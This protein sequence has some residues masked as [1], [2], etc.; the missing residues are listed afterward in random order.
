MQPLWA[1]EDSI[2][3]L[4]GGEWQTFWWRRGVSTSST[5]KGQQGNM[6]H[7]FRERQGLAEAAGVGGASAREETAQRGWDTRAGR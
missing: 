5:H 6:L 3:G 4:K 2:S 1:P 7:V